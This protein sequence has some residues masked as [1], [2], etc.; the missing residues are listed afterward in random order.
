[1]R[2][3]SQLSSSLF[4]L[5]RPNSG[6]PKVAFIAPREDGRTWSNL[7]SLRSG[8]I[9]VKSAEHEFDAVFTNNVCSQSAI[10][11]RIVKAT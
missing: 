2:V 11:T 7:G 5:K 6:T 4:V 3:T 1:M 9:A 8:G 10:F